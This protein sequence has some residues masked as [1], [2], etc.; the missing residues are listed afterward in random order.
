MARAGQKAGLIYGEFFE[1]S[2]VSTRS[3]KLTPREFLGIDDAMG[4]AVTAAKRYTKAVRF[5]FGRQDTE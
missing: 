1:H 4:D 5:G 3:T 2:P